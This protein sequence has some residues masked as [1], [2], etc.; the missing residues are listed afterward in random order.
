LLFQSF[1]F[2]IFFPIVFGLYWTVFRGN[3]AQQNAFL[4]V[5]SFIFYGWWDWRF[6]GLMVFS[7]GID[8]LLAIQIDRAD[9]K[10]KKKTLLI[11]SLVSNLGILGFF[12]YFNF[13]IENFTEVIRIFGHTPKIETLNIILP[14]G[15]SFYT[16]Q[17][18]SYTIDVYNGKIASCKNLVTYFGYISFFPQLVA[19]PIERAGHLLPQFTKQ[20]FFNRTMATEGMR[21]ILLGLFMK[22]VVADGCGRIVDQ[23]YAN[24]ENFPGYELTMGIILFA[25]QVYADFAGYS[26]I[27]IGT[28]SLLG[29]RLMRNFAFPFFST[30]IAMLWR[31]WHISLTSWFRD[32]FFVLFDKG[33]TSRER[34][35]FNVSLIYL[36]S[37][38]W[39]GASWNYII[40]GLMNAFFVAI[41]ILKS[42]PHQ[43]RKRA[44]NWR[45]IPTFLMFA[46]ALSITRFRELNDTIRYYS[47]L[48]SMSPGQDHSILL[49]PDALLTLLMIC[50]LFVFEWNSRFKQ[51][52][53]AMISAW[54]SPWL[55][56]GLYVI[57]TLFVLHAAG[58]QK[59]F[60]YFKF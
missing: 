10:R 35:A 29:F 28:A 39:H 27:A 48:F 33:T 47:S 24:P 20:R 30:D 31:R 59:P 17:A 58:H 46:F 1:E 37:G 49:Q 52:G 44:S 53:L 15:I 19:G 2:A 54:K 55:R 56:I 57:I 3:I 50:I 14:V 41:H 51:Y 5:A 38:C 21:R 13:F 18:L 26:E 6:L 32:D 16:L 11:L 4:V 9:S 42:T 43:Q 45:M 12:K 8:F 7:A 34:F 22:V 25:I 23:L 40:W 60:F 36:L